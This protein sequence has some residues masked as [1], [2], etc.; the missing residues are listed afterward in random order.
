MS[1]FGYEELIWIGK[2]STGNHHL[3][4]YNNEDTHVFP[5][6]NSPTHNKHQITLDL[7]NDDKKKCYDLSITENE[8][9][10]LIFIAKKQIQKTKNASLYQINF[11]NEVI[12]LCKDNMVRRYAKSENLNWKMARIAIEH[13]GIILLI[14]NYMREQLGDLSA[15]SS[16]LIRKSIEQ[17]LN[18]DL[19]AYDKTA[20]VRNVLVSII[21]CEKNTYDYEIDKSIGKILSCIRLYYSLKELTNINIEDYQK[22]HEKYTIKNNQNKALIKLNTKDNGKYY[23]KKFKDVSL[24]YF[25]HPS[26]TELF[27]RISTIAENS[28]IDHDALVH[29]LAYLI[30]KLK[31]EKYENR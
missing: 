24:L 7:I 5:S 25:A 15:N 29:E 16:N 18:I 22:L 23:W 3:R 1:G 4:L 17:N 13:Y 11:I 30:Y 28:N 6:I 27:Q 20:R 31:F 2:S 8:W 26:V 14:E 19:L 9:E 21:L 12:K 10:T